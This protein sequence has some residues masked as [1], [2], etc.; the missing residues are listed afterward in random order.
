MKLLALLWGLAEA[1]FF[2]IVPDVL[3]SVL[4][5][6]KPRKEALVA[7]GYALLGAL[8]GSVVMYVWGST[9]PG[10]AAAFLEYV[11]AVSAEMIEG[12]EDS[13]QQNGLWALFTGPSSGIP[14]KVYGV[15]V[16][17]LQI[18]FLFFF[19]VSIPAR[20][21]RFVLTVLITRVIAHRLL[22]R[23]PE[24]RKLQ[25]LAGFWIVLYA[26]FWTLMPN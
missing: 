16:G 26:A 13:L 12:V 19:L 17:T 25:I 4:A 8:L 10:A 18:S 1:T 22:R 7:C 6:R 9:H 20:L 2:F 23:W 21:V 3:L 14:Y 24:K 15:K 5:I 11:P